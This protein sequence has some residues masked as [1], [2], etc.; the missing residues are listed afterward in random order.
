M[1]KGRSRGGSETGFLHKISV[2]RQ[3]LSKKPGFFCLGKGRSLLITI[4]EG[5]RPFFQKG[6]ERAIA[7]FHWELFRICPVNIRTIAIGCTIGNVNPV[8][9]FFDS[10]VGCQTIAIRVHDSDLSLP[11]RELM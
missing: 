9:V 7:A 8:G 10:A 2:K 5:D 6:K 3:R 4:P 11:I 1:V